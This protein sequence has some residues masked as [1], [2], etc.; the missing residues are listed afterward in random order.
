MASEQSLEISSDG[1]AETSANEA[2]NEDKSL[3][4]TNLENNAEESSKKVSCKL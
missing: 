4:S 1:R 2:S 3:T